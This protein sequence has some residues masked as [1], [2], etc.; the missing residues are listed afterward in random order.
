MQHEHPRAHQPPEGSSYREAD[1]RSRRSGSLVGVGPSVEE[2]TEDAA[3]RVVDARTCLSREEAYLLLSI[4]GEW[5]PSYGDT[6][7]RSRRAAAR[8]WLERRAA[9]AAPFCRYP[10]NQGRARKDRTSPPR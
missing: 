7:D 6:A 10:S 3:R 2:A 8:R 5:R 1:H 9:V 4:I